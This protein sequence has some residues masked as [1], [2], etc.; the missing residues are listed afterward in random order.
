[1]A[2]SDSF[3]NE[4]IPEVD[5]VID[6][7]GTSY[8]LTTPGAYNEQTLS[9]DPP[10]SR[11][12]DGLIADQSVAISVASMAGSGLSSDATWMG[13]KILILKA[14]ANPKPTESIEIEGLTYPLSKVVPIKP[15]D[16][17]VVYM[18]DITR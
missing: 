9:N 4:L 13:K 18:L 1:M 12:V 3:Y 14:S 5:Q 7:L 6:E 10:S 17:T 16:V 15:A 11:P 8:V 2:L